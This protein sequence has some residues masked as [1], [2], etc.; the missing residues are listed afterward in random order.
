[1][2]GWFNVRLKRTGTPDYEPPILIRL[3]EPDDGIP[4][5]GETIQVPLKGRGVRAIVRAISSPP[6]LAADAVCTVT[7]DE[8]V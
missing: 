7:L 1:M 3:R 4:G 5:I 8:V 2:A 6:G